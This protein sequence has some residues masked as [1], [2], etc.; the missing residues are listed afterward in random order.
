MKKQLFDHFWLSTIEFLYSNQFLYSGTNDAIL[1]C[2]LLWMLICKTHALKLGN[3]YLMFLIA[4]NLF[5]K[6]FINFHECS[7]IQNRLNLP[8]VIDL[9]TILFF[10]SCRPQVHGPSSPNESF[11]WSIDDSH[12][13]RA[14]SPSE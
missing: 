8:D 14:F 10:S 2:K 4:L 1:F 7:V 13:H 11:F 9:V 5:V 3:Q 6:F 12:Y